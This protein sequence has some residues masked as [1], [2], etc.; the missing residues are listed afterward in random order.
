MQYRKENDIILVKMKLIQ[1]FALNKHW[2]L[3]IFHII[4]LY[5]ADLPHSF[6]SIKRFVHL[7]HV[8]GF[9]ICTDGKLLEI[10]HRKIIPN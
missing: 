3:C 8:K 4:Q 10:L 2:N 6:F 1:A 5:I 9:F 7:N